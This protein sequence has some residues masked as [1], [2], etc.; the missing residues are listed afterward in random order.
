MADLG[1]GPHRSDEIAERQGRRVQAIAPVR[2]SLIAKGM[3]WSPGRGDV[4]F[5]IPF[6]D[7]FLKRIAPGDDGNGV[8]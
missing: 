7:E 1:P 3:I 8:S 5:T 2:H 4:A 6:F